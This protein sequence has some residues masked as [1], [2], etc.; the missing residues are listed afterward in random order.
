V[1]NSTPRFVSLTPLVISHERVSLDLVT[2]N[3]PVK[4][5][6][7]LDFDLENSTVSTETP[8]NDSLQDPEDPIRNSPYPN[9]E[10]SIIDEDGSEV[11][12]LFIVEHKERRVSMTMHIRRPQP[13]KKYIARAEMVQNQSTLQTLT[14]PFILT[15]NRP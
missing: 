7:L 6:V 4:S 14:V 8:P 3:F 2:E 11:A 5:N 10:L 12:N 1:A 9:V 13:G 15:P